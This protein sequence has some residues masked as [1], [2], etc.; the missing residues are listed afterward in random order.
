MTA[1]QVINVQILNQL[2]SISQRLNKDEGIHCK[3]TKD[4]KKNPKYEK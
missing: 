2:Q 4:L 1:Q 3:K